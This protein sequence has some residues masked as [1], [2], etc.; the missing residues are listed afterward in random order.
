M[1]VAGRT[2]GERSCGSL[3]GRQRPD[4][5]DDLRL[6]SSLVQPA[7]PGPAWLTTAFPLTLIFLQQIQVLG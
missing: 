3:Q 4:W 2:R 1:Q 5:S 7:Q 6:S